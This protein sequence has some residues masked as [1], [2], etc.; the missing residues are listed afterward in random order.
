[1]SKM[2]SKV[3][4]LHLVCLPTSIELFILLSFY[5]LFKWYVNWNRIILLPFPFTLQ[6]LQASFPWIPYNILK[7]TAITTGRF[8]YHF[9]SR[10][11]LFITNGDSQKINKGHDAKGLWRTKPLQVCFHQTSCIYG[12]RNFTEEGQREW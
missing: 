6:P 1:M 9:S 4:S 12:S 2:K 5:C 11:P 7:P 10:T 8:G 3:L